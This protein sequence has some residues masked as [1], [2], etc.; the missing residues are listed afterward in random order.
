VWTAPGD[1]PMTIALS[2]TPTWASPNKY[3]VAHGG[4][5]FNQ[6]RRL[7]AQMHFCDAVRALTWFYKFVYPYIVVGIPKSEVR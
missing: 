3:I 1:P 6:L 2:R 7:M 4:C 5:R